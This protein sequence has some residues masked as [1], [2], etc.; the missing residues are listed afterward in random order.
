MSSDQEMDSAKNLSISYSVQGKC[1]LYVGKGP[2]ATLEAISDEW[3][4]QT[5]C[6]ASPSE[7]KETHLFVGGEGCCVIQLLPKWVEKLWNF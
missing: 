7:W 5:Y 1:S 3:D 6:V 2:S 4:E